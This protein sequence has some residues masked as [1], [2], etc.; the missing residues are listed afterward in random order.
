MLG[1]Q[2]L[3]SL[4]TW[5]KS[6]FAH[7]F[8]TFESYIR[9]KHF[10]FSGIRGVESET[11]RWIPLKNLKILVGT[12]NSSGAAVYAWKSGKGF[13]VGCELRNDWVRLQEDIADPKINFIEPFSWVQPAEDEA[14]LARFEAVVRYILLVNDKCS[15]LTGRL[16]FFREHFP[17]AC[18][19]IAQ[20]IERRENRTN[21]SRR[22][23]HVSKLSNP[24]NSKY[25]S[26]KQRQQKPTCLATQ[27]KPLQTALPTSHSLPPPRSSPLLRRPQPQR[28]I[29]LHLQ[30][31]TSKPS[32]KPSPH[33]APHSYHRPPPPSQPASKT[34][35]T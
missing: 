30:T 12:L 2:T 28:P 1:K 26:L 15:A 23:S 19:D 31:T 32:T 33:S 18:H 27:P 5:A 3:P 6:S 25:Q 35:P 16:S 8:A 21:T 17:N 34:T 20:Q 22:P 29:L 14:G 13:D 10:A 9:S 24:S 4:V 7:D 11:G